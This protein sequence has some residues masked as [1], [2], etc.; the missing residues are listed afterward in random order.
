MTK[1]L[2]LLISLGVSFTAGAIGSLATTPN[3]PNWYQTLDKPA[4]NPPNWVFGPV[5]TLLYILMGIAL[6]LVWTSPVKQKQTKL[7][8][9]VWFGAQLVLNALWSIVFF[10]LHLTGLGIVVIFALLASILVTARL[11]WPI[12]RTAAYLL[13]PY[14]MWVLFASMLN[15]AIA[16]LN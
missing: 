8:P 2:K 1:P 7:I 9:Y 6:Y 13:I 11:F 14:S 10:G 3:I 15:I 4:F 16:T 12:S 5:W